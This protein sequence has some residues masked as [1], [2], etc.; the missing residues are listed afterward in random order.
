[1]SISLCTKTSRADELNIYETRW[2]LQVLRVWVSM[3]VNACGEEQKLL[4]QVMQTTFWILF[5]PSI[6]IQVFLELKPGVRITRNSQKCN[7]PS[8]Q[9]WPTTPTRIMPTPA[10]NWKRMMNWFLIPDLS[11]IPS[12]AQGCAF[13]QTVSPTAENSQLLHAVKF[14][15]MDKVPENLDG[16]RFPWP[17]RCL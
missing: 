3:K 13:I 1:M 8:E 14:L 2:V 6:G 9:Y 5:D 10:Q 15:K 16:F 17:L 7:F 4:K 11:F 12:A